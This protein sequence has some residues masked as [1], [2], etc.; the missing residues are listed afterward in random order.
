[1]EDI[2]K[3]IV[4]PFVSDIQKLEN[5]IKVLKHALSVLMIRTESPSSWANA[6]S[7]LANYSDDQLCTVARESAVDR[8]SKL[9]IKTT[10]NRWV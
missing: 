3:T 2:L 8:I 7:A 1:M 10:D 9:S 5:E 4:L 6:K